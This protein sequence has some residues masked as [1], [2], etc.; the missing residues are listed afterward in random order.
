[1]RY[2]IAFAIAIV[3]LMFFGSARAC[4][5]PDVPTFKQSLDSAET[6]FVFRL[7]STGLV[8]KSQNTRDMAGR[9]EMVRTL[10]GSP[11]FGYLRH[12]AEWCG[13]LRLFVGHYYLVATRQRGPVLM[14]G[15]GDRSIVDISGD[16]SRVYPAQ[17]PDQLWQTQIEHYLAGR[18]L[19]KNFDPTEI[20]ERVQAFPPV[21]AEAW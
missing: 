15:R 13:G 19:R 8:E 1:M 10:K 7:V 5:E 17:K 6:V 20:M 3:A 18:P 2:P 12:N 14:L 16:Y 4:S 9:I 11:Q 21:P